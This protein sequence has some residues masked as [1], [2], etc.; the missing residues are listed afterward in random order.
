MN[1]QGGALEFDV[2]LNNGQI[3]KGLRTTR[4][5]IEG[6]DNSI[7]N[8]TTGLGS[9]F[10]FR[11]ASAFA[12]KVANIRG[13]FQQLEVAFT[14]MLKSK[15]KAD[16]LMQQIVHTAAITPFG[17]QEVASGAKQ[18]LAYGEAAETVNKTLVKLGNI[19]SGLSIPLNDIV[20]L[21]GTTM[22]Q[23]RLFTQ[24][25]RQFMGRGIP[26]IQE[27][28][29]ELGKTETQINE[30]VTAG[31][32]GFPEVQKVI[33]N[34]TKEGGMFFNLMEKQSKTIS[35][36]ISNLGDAIESTLNKIGKSNEEAISNAISGVAYMI[37]HYEEIGK[38][39]LELVA[40]Y[41]TYKAVLITV[42][43]IQRL[44]MMVLRQAVLEKSLAAK[45]G[46]QLSNAEAIAAARTK[47]LTI[48]QQGL[49]KAVKAATA[50]MMSN[51]Y[52]LVAA[53]VTSLGYAIYKLVTY[54][55]EAEKAQK[56][57]NEALNESRTS[58]ISEQ[59]ELARLKGELEATEKGTK[60]YS[61]LKEQI[62]SKYG[63]YKNNLEDEIEKVGLLKDTYDDL[64][65][66]IESSWGARQ[67]D[68]F[69]KQEFD[70]LDNVMSENL[71]KIQNRLIDKLG[72]ETGMKIYSKIRDAIID[73]REI[74]INGFEVIS[75]LDK[76]TLEALDKVAGKEDRLFDIRNRAVEGYIS[77][78]KK[79]RTLFDSMDSKAK[80]K[81]GI[82]DPGGNE[83]NNVEV[84]TEKFKSL[85]EQIKDAKK[86]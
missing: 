76:E 47:L 44:N 14:T 17:L 5:L 12:M 11:Q 51:P 38:T 19:A 2:L 32:I 25:V 24:D 43:A 79:A 36:Q 67:Y 27:L 35:G 18:L 69:I 54:Q 15:G 61:D 34:L 37:E 46:I 21:Y 75:G 6:L 29:K 72:D 63:Q 81:F 22:V 20:Y 16:A 53:A 71:G 26:L 57:L 70:N 1:I 41:G 84:Q 9:F 45:A 58:I 52:V 64:K 86:T 28:A 4:K 31:K 74:N 13:E 42:A 55:N 59:R 77:E 56:R 8:V 10:M 62:V 65:K 82:T 60:K 39:I 23:G 66:A 33:N 49:V 78:I 68:K 7:R 3:E 80:N 83:S 40:V 30:M 85:S 50:A 73:G 48:A